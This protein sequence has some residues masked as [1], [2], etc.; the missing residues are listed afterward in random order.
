MCMSAPL[1]G[2]RSTTPT[3][4]VPSPAVAVD[5]FVAL[6]GR[7][8]QRRQGRGWRGTAL[9][10]VNELSSPAHLGPKTCVVTGLPAQGDRR[11]SARSRRKPRPARI[12][13]DRGPND[14]QPIRP[15]ATI[16]A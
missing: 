14:V 13:H 7:L 9:T 11:G 3:V 1:P 5:L 8:V 16:S 15:V 2:Y 12:R 10:K 4:P 6:G